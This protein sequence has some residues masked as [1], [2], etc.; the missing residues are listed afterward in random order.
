MEMR[1]EKQQ[2]KALR[3]EAIVNQYTELLNKGAAKTIAAKQI[4]TMF[5]V[6]ERTV[7][8]AVNNVSK[9]N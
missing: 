6:S 7:Y 4:A 1:T 9:N 2:A 3:N 8:N 5:R